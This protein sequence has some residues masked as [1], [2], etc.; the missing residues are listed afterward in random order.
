MSFCFNW[1]EVD[2][3]SKMKKDALRKQTA[4]ELERWEKSDGKEF[5]KLAVDKLQKVLDYHCTLK[6]IMENK[7]RQLDVVILDEQDMIREYIST[8]VK[9]T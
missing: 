6:R 3:L 4:E 8:I 7:L 9:L 1:L 5:N 2:V